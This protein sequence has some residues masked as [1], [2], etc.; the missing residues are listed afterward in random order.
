MV[1]KMKNMPPYEAFGD[2][3]SPS[4]SY[5]QAGAVLDIAAEFAV[6]SRDIEQLTTIAALWVQLGE[7]LM[8][9][10]AEEDDT[11]DND[12]ELDSTP[13]NPIGFTGGRPITSEEQP[14]E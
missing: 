5:L 8:S 7:R 10:H 3:L 2:T 9:G 11:E 12:V 13:R 14:N 4:V 6:D 1:A